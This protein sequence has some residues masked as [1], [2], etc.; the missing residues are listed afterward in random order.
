MI[1]LRDGNIAVE[2][3]LVEGLRWNAGYN[4]CVRVVCARCA[5]TIWIETVPRPADTS[6]APRSL[7]LDAKQHC[8][9]G[10]LWTALP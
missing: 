1:P 7:Q 8:R 10:E 3:H 6:A 2:C 4:D 5:S 9:V